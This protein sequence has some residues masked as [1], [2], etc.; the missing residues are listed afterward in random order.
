MSSFLHDLTHLYH[1]QMDRH[2]NRPFL[3]SVMAAC[4]LIAIANGKVSFSQRIRMDQIIETLDKLKVF[5]PHEGVNLFNHYIALITASHENGHTEVT[6]ILKSGATDPNT[7]EL[8]IR[9]CLAVSENN[10]VV[11]MDEKKEIA[12]LCKL[13]NVE[14][15]TIGLDHLS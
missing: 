6:N 7:A 5:D 1:E 15:K 8:L 9:I 2:R 13:L 12:A 3:K 4:A 11:V 10:N 14:T